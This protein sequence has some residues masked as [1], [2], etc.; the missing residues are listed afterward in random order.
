MEK[1]GND[2]W[3]KVEDVDAYGEEYK[4]YNWIV[5]NRALV[6]FKLEEATMLWATISEESFVGVKC[7]Y[8][9]ATGKFN[10][11]MAVGTL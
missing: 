2:K 9:D 8:V 5:I 11:M 10:K 4:K 7:S 1:L 6:L 3:Y